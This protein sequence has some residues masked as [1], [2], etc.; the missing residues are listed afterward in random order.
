MFL[1]KE[2]WDEKDWRWYLRVMVIFIIVLVLTLILISSIRLSDNKEVVNI[3]A[4]GGSLVSIVLGIIAIVISV[5]QNNSTQEINSRIS[6]KIERL[7]E[8]IINVDNKVSN[9]DIDTLMNDTEKKITES[10]MKLNKDM[11]SILKENNVQD[12]VIEKIEEQVPNRSYKEAINTRHY[13]EENLNTL[14]NLEKKKKKM[15][16]KYI[17]SFVTD[18]KYDIEDIISQ[19]YLIEYMRIRNVYPISFHEHR[20]D[21]GKYYYK[22]G[23]V[24]ERDTN[25]KKVKMEGMIANFMD[26][27]FSEFKFNRTQ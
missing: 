9:F 12:E 7:D 10:Y 26:I 1:N 13:F 3:L 18:E 2:E 15:K 17:M 11:V 24:L 23:I 16:Q 4:I 19:I 22:I 8:K 6:E 27:N 5:I 21:E 14:V 25:M 20:S